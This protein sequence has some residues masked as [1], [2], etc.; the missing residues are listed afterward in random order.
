MECAEGQPSVLEIC[1]SIHK[2]ICICVYAS[3]S[4]STSA[5]ASWLN[6]RTKN[7]RRGKH[8]DVESPEKSSSVSW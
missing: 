5:S 8:L 7:A 4:A 1:I 2:C 3:A 6:R